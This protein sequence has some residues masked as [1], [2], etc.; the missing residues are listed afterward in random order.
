MTRRARQTFRKGRASGSV[1]LTYQLIMA[2]ILEEANELIHGE[3]RKD[4]GDPIESF[5][6]IADLWKP[7]LKVDIT[8]EQVALCMI[9]LKV[10]RF[11]N[12]G[13]RDSMVDVAGYAGCI[14]LIRGWE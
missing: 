9:Q 6:R 2:N 13:T 10:A 8:T 14:G 11:L 7:I 1:A 5:Q 4:Y 3:R 12:G